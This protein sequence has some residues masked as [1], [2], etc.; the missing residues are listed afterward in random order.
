MS[1]ISEAKLQIIRTLLEQAPDSAVRTLLRAL[2]DGELDAGLMAVRTLVEQE[3]NERRARNVV[4][5]PLA[6]LCGV[7]ARLSTIHFPPRTLKLIWK[8]LTAVAPPDVDRAVTMVADWR[9]DEGSPVDYDAL[10]AVAVRELR[11]CENRHFAAAAQAADEGSGRE[12]LIGCLELAANTR[13]ALERL[14]QW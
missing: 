8:G 3:A 4:L 13:R 7:D 12:T 2:C 6:S 11:S 1:Q 5:A 14:P 9:P 10:C